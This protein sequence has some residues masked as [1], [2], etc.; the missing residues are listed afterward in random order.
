MKLTEVV[1]K[2]LDTLV[3][4]MPVSSGGQGSVGRLTPPGKGRFVLRGLVA[5]KAPGLPLI[6]L[7][8]V[9]LSAQSLKSR[10][11]SATAAAAA[12]LAA[13]AA[14]VTAATVFPA[15]CSTFSWW[16]RVFL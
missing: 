15:A 13:L 3:T 6:S 2:V 16:I 11:T 14:A 9:E 1:V 12:A 8:S 5:E 10:L 4:R 7:S